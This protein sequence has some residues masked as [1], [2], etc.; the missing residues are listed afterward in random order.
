MRSL[1]AWRGSVLLVA[2][3]ILGRLAGGALEQKGGSELRILTGH[4]FTGNDQPVQ[5]A[6]VY[7]KN[8]K[9]LSIKT[10]ISEPDGS[11]RFTGI[12]LNVDYEIYAEHEG[13]RSDTKTLS[14]FDNRKEP[15]VT[16]R[17]HSK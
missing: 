12:A 5:K 17:L 10:Y 11:Y 3:L 6:V 4:V 13:S 9:T 2:G 8:T 1:V 16:L 15:R 7:L 14:A